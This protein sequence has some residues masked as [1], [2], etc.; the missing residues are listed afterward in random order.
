[1]RCWTTRETPGLSPLDK[2]NG[3]DA[4]SQ[5]WTVG[6]EALEALSVILNKNYLAEE[7]WSRFRLQTEANKLET[8]ILEKTHSIQD[9]DE[10]K[11]AI[12]NC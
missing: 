1:M 6:T 11:T 5:G 9:I 10:R 8:K 4:F 3:L 2:K 12:S 7:N